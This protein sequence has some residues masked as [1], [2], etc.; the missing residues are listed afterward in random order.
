MDEKMN[1]AVR[2]IYESLTDEQKEKAKA[3]KT[4]EELTAL[5]AREGVEMPD[6]VLEAAAGGA[7]HPRCWGFEIGD[8]EPIC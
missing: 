7:F 5:A 4:V 8:V 6:E 3:C 1:A 2:G